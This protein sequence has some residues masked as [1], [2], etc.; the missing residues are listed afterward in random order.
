MKIFINFFI[1]IT[2][3]CLISCTDSYKER[4]V[5]IVTEWHDKEF[6]FSSKSEI[7][8]SEYMVVSYMDSTICSSCRI[9]SWIRFVEELESINP[10]VGS[11]LILSPSIKNTD[12]FL[13]LRINSIPYCIDYGDEI[14]KQNNIPK[15]DL[16]RTF[17]LDKDN[18]VI[19]IGNPI[20]KEN[21]KLLY[22][23]R[24]NEPI[25]DSYSE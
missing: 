23:N 15:E 21:V 11:L 19:L 4:A 10:K 16:F 2:I 13:Q 18:K 20:L 12:D 1:S 24:V 22:Q 8:N 7:E 17:L 3:L 25:R 9:G 5:I 6:V 14:Y